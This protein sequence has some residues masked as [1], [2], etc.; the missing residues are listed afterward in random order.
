MAAGSYIISNS[1]YDLFNRYDNRGVIMYNA[2]F[3][4]MISELHSTDY[5]SA[6]NRFKTFY[7]VF[8]FENTDY[9]HDNRKDLIGTLIDKF[10]LFLK[11]NSEGLEENIKNTLWNIFIDTIINDDN[12]DVLN[13][14]CEAGFKNKSSNVESLNKI[15]KIIHQI[16][17][18]PGIKRKEGRNTISSLLLEGTGIQQNTIPYVSSFLSGQEGNIKKQMKTLKNKAAL[19]KI[20]TKKNII[21]AYFPIGHSGGRRAKRT[22][23]RTTRRRR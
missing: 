19:N 8:I 10:L 2:L 7:K 11:S 3:M 16:Y 21:D 18:E 4:D 13:K 15:C 22:K 23:C 6:N 9:I 20:I 14:M 5:T 17:I 1:E 12:I